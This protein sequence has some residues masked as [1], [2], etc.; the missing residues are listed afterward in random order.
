MTVLR[1][2]YLFH[3]IITYL[4]YSILSV[5]HTALT[6]FLVSSWQSVVDTTIGGV[7]SVFAFECYHV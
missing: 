3:S 4:V 1:K 6:T 7:S 5:D 2:L